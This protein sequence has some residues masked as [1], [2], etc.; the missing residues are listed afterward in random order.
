ME[1]SK[2]KKILE[3]H[4]LWIETNG[5]QGTRADLHSA[6]LTGAYLYGANLYRA[7]LRGADLRGAN[8]KDANLPTVNFSGA[9]LT[10]AYLKGAILY[11]ANLQGANLYHANLTGANLYDA[12]LWRANLTDANL[13]G[14]YLCRANLTDAILPDISWIIPGCLAQLN[15]IKESFYL[16][17][18]NKLDNFIQDSFGFIIQ[19]NGEQKTFDILAGDRIIRGIP[20]W[21]K[22]SGMKQIESESV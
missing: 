12:N 15:E 9:D 1:A 14:A 18:E 16:E 7:D 13:G 17:K 11:G 5:V 21:V 20:H 19:D 10:G 8:L 3:Q 2:L 4:K 6:N 22:Y